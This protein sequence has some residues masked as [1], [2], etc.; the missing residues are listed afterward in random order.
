MIEPSVLMFDSIVFPSIM[1][2]RMN[3]ILASIAKKSEGVGQEVK[4]LFLGF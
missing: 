4:S 3:V 1:T 2:K